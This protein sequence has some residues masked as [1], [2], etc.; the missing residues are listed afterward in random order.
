MYTPDRDPRHTPPAP[1]DQPHVAPNPAAP[2]RDLGDD[3]YR[4]DTQ[5]GRQGAHAASNISRYYQPARQYEGADTESLFRARAEFFHM[6]DVFQVPP[7]LRGAC[8]PFSL[9]ASDHNL[10]TLVLDNPMHTAEDL[11]ELINRRVNT[12]ARD[13]RLKGD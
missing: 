11:W 9:R 1:P 7:S 4:L 2:A 12:T 13:V 5:T 10:P 3:I 6:C 8:V